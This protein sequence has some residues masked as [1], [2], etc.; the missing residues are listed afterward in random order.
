MG[1]VVRRHM[2]RK[3]AIAY[4]AE[5]VK[6]NVA[7]DEQREDSGKWPSP[8]FSACMRE[9][10]RGLQVR[11]SEFAA[12]QVAWENKELIFPAPEERYDT[13][14]DVV[15]FWGLDRTQRIRCVISREAA[16]DD[17]F[18]GDNR[19]KLEVFRENRP[20]IEEIARRKYLSGHVE[21]DGT[22]LIR[23]ADIPH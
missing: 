13:S 21:P 14:R 4:I 22:V 9:I 15:V 20:A 23:T 10:S 16:L 8:I 5:W 17:H 18:H 3:E 2:D 6:S 7:A 19:N 11:P 1:D 12:W